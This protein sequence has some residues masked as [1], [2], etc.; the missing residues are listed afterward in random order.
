VHFGSTFT[1]YLPRRAT[2]R[3]PSEPPRTINPVVTGTGRVLIVD[4]EEAIRALVEFTLS[5]LGYEVTEAETA[6]DGVNIYREKLEPASAS[7][8]SSSTSRS[9]RHGRQRKPSS[10]SSKSIRR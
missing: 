7:M 1:I 4:D 9:R 2:S 5:R 10:A 3:C 6:L 8:R